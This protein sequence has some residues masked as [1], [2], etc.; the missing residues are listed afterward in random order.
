MKSKDTNKDF[1]FKK[2]SM[3][4][5]KLSQ[6]DKTWAENK[7][8]YYKYNYKY[9]NE[10]HYL[11]QIPVESLNKEKLWEVEY[12]YNKDWFRSDNFIKNHKGIHILFAGC[13]YTEGVGE[14]IEHNWSNVLYSKINKDY[15]TSGYFNIAKSGFGSHKI[16]TNT[17]EYIKNYGN[18]DIIFIFHPNILRFFNW[19][20][21]KLK[22]NY[23]QK[24]P[25]FKKNDKNSATKEEYV[26]FFANWSISWMLFLEY[27]KSNNIKVVW[28][29]W[30]PSD[31]ENIINFDKINNEYVDSN[32]D[33]S[34][35]TS[36]IKDNK[37]TKRDLSARDGHPGI[38]S[39]KIWAEKFYNKTLEM[40]ILYD[41]K[42]YKKNN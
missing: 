20:N 36:I 16:I 40:S 23:I 17:I 4:S 31:N 2:Q 26:N 14:N 37:P 7:E 5:L 24:Y 6:F 38:I 18:P 28:S 32:I 33:E 34:L 30:D 3:D 41:Y 27:L 29:C 19:D 9:L 10:Y 13:S 8:Q 1:I 12:R 39:N 11:D 15:E 21:D 25:S 35:I 42:N 22:W